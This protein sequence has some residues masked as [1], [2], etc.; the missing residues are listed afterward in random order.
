MTNEEASAQVKSILDENRMTAQ[1]IEVEST[2]TT[3]DAVTYGL[4]IKVKAS[5][6]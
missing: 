5:K 1:D 3:G 6:A 2:I 4:I